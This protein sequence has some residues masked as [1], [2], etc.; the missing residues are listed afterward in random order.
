MEK[1]GGSAY[2]GGVAGQSSGSIKTSYCSKSLKYW[3]N[4]NVTA[5]TSADMKKDQ[6]AWML[7]TTNGTATNSKVWSR[8]D[9]YPIFAT[10]T[11]KPIVKVVFNDDGATSNKYSTY[12]GTVAIPSNPTP[13]TGYIFDGWYNGTTKVTS[14]TVFSAGFN[15][16]CLCYNF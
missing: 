16:E 7:N 3:M 15:F 13:A 5:V 4:S 11:Y 12:K 10:S 14:S 8:T 6:F 9:G 2:G 1:N